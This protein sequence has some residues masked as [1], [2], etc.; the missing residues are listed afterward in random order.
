MLIM[1]NNS[2]MEDRLSQDEEFL[3]MR[4]RTNKKF[5]DELRDVLGINDGPYLE[6]DPGFYQEIGRRDINE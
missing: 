2:D 4:L 5:R 1:S 6:I 3:I